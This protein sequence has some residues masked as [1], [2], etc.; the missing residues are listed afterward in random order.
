MRLLLT[1][2]ILCA[3]HVAQAQPTWDQAK[4]E[5]VA[6]AVQNPY[7]KA[8][9]IYQDGVPV[10]EYGT[11]HQAYQLF[12]IRKSL[13]S[14]LFGIYAGE[15]K[16]NL[17]A[18]MAQLGIDDKQGLTSDEKQAKV[19][20]VLRA[21]SGIY[22]PAAYETPGMMKNRPP[23]G[24][25][26]PGE[27]WFYNNW[28][29]NVLTT[30]FEKQTGE[31]VFDAFRKKIA[32]PLKMEDFD[33]KR[34]EYYR[35]TMSVHP[36]TLWF[37]SASDLA[38][39]GLMLLNNGSWDGKQVIDPA[40]IKEST[41]TFSD[42]GILGGYGYCWWTARDGNHFPFVTLPQGTYSARGTGEQTLLII[43]ERKIVIVHLTEVTSPDQP[44][45]RVVELG[46]LLKTVLE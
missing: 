23:R 27:H 34:Q 12:S 44:M 45:M 36:A 22:H 3:F 31:R 33:I 40:W 17:N 19:I 43:P 1:L 15:G 26:K 39:L 28:D 7:T 32:E 41:T 13:V 5:R 25:Y 10:Y 21:R 42:I 9:L 8:L 18:T 2:L 29:F 46:R 6:K 35:D 14:L 37:M 38:R 11:K 4:Q 24:Q 16:I 30:I 20:D